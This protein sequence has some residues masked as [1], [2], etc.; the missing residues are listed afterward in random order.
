MRLPTGVEP[1][2]REFTGGDPYMRA[3][4]RNGA[5]REWVGGAVQKYAVWRILKAGSEEWATLHNKVKE[6]ANTAR[7]EKSKGNKSASKAK[8]ENGGATDS[9][10]TV[11]EP[12]PK[13]KPKR[14]SDAKATAAGVD[15]GTVE[16]VDAIVAAAPAIA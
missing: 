13:P 14:S 9:G 2:F 6:Q 7:S 16:K 10:T 11:L 12:A 4:D 8:P 15:R 5:R 1:Q 3:W